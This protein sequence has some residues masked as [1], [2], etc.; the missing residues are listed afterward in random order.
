VLGFALAATEGVQL[1]VEEVERLGCEA[2]LFSLA[3]HAYWGI[4]ALVQARSVR[5]KVREGERK[6]RVQACHQA[7]TM[8][9]SL[10]VS[11]M[12]GA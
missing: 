12:L 6:R 11:S 8:P 5:R 4:W 10:F 7:T 2:D 1:S 9:T 3:S